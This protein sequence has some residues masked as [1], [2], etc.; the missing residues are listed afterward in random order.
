MDTDTAGLEDET[1]PRKS[2]LQQQR[3]WAGE[4]ER[5]QLAGEKSARMK[6]FR[7]RVVMEGDITLSVH[8]LLGWVKEGLFMYHIPTSSTPTANVFLRISI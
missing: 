7:N 6:G 5:G 4:A 2:N 3:S 8:D 1:T